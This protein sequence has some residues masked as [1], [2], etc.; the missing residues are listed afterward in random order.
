M[1]IFNKN[2]ENKKTTFQIQ[3][4]HCVSC[5]MNIDGYLEDTPGVIKAETNFAKSLT[6][7]SYDPKI[8]TKEKVKRIIEQVGYKVTSTFNN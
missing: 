8:I 7:V 6:N 2:I 3:G 1:A 4:M 5:A